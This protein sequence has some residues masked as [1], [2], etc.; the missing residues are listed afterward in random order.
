MDGLHL[1]IV[2]SRFS[3]KIP[4]FVLYLFI[5][6]RQLIHCVIHFLFILSSRLRQLLRNHILQLFLLLNVLFCAIY[7]SQF[8]L[9]LDLLLRNFFFDPLLFLCLRCFVLKDYFLR[10]RYHCRTLNG[11]HIRLSLDC[12]SKQLT[13]QTVQHC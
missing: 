6:L 13:I 3:I 10:R 9:R 7:Q 2:F 11:R 4:L 12:R 1:L 5:L 8:L